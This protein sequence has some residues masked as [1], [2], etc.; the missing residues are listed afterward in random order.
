M[1]SHLIFALLS[2]ASPPGEPRRDAVGH[3]E[4]EPAVVRLTEQREG[5]H[6]LHH[7]TIV[8]LLPEYPDWDVR[9]LSVTIWCLRPTSAHS[10]PGW[11]HKF[12]HDGDTVLVTWKA[13][14]KGVAPGAELAGFDVAFGRPGAIIGAYDLVVEAT[15]TSLV[16]GNQGIAR[17]AGG[18]GYDCQP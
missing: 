1:I 7:Y 3:V 6:W 8:N 5:R 18:H 2:A 13:A 16:P 4:E 15:S 12:K 11:Q 10:P 14:S 9:E 17:M